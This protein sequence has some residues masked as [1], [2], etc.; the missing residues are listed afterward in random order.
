[1][2]RNLKT[3]KAQIVLAEYVLTFVLVVVAITVMTF[4]VRRVVQGRIR[5]ATRHMAVQIRAAG[6]TG[7]VWTQY[8]PYYANSD[9]IRSQQ[10][11]Q[12]EHLL[13]HLRGVGIFRQISNEDRGTT[14][15]GS[16]LPP[17]DAN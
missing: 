17:K 10:S 6:F 14:A 4:Y 1:M 16:Q 8:E 9:A 12:E 3:Y 15:A 2:F 5:G 11:L 13:P 7:N